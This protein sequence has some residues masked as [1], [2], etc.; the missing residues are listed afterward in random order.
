LRGGSA[1]GAIALVP[2]RS[3]RAVDDDPRGIGQRL[4]RLARRYLYMSYVFM[5][6]TRSPGG[7][8]ASSNALTMTT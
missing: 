2:Y 8:G 7:F 4:I 3:S 5:V 6:A 1:V